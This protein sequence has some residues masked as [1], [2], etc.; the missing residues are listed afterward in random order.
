M[1][2]AD[3]ATATA[4]PATS[5]VNL[6]ASYFVPEAPG[7]ARA[8][9]GLSSMAREWGGVS[10][11]PRLPSILLVLGLHVALIA[12]LWLTRSPAPRPA[13]PVLLN[14]QWLEAA[15]P[16]RP[17]PPRELPTPRMP[18]LEQPAVL[19]VPVIPEVQIPVQV[20]AATPAP[21][22][23]EPVSAPT[24]APVPLNSTTPPA[25]AAAP[26]RVPPSAVHYLA[27]PRLNYPLMSRRAKE[28]GVVVLR[29][30]VDIEGRL[31]DAVVHRSSGFARLDEQAL[32]DIRSAR[33]APQTEDGRAIAWETLAPLAYD[34]ER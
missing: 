25:A 30:L 20:Q 29:I 10:A 8:G 17:Q 9:L 34:L 31:A 23:R 7:M 16:P 19:P 14:V 22:V 26:K 2:D 24:S 12:L 5:P 28:S 27:K 33:F 18:S 4:L 32:I 3:I 1:Y 11:R 6:A 21:V 13:E 15:E